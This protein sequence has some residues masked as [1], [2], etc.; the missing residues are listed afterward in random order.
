[1]TNREA[2]V[3]AQLL[4]LNNEKINIPTIDRFDI[5]FSTKYRKDIA[6]ALNIKEQVLQNCFSKLRK[7]G[8][9]VDNTIPRKYQ[10]SISEEGLEL[11]LKL[12]LITDV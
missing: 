11:T 7:K 5:I 12:K 10:I 2:A 6:S 1:M 9:I 3:F 4:Y 8:L